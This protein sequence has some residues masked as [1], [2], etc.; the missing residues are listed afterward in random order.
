MSKERSAIK[1]VVAREEIS[2]KDM[3][4]SFFDILEKEGDKLNKLHQ[5]KNVKRVSMFWKTTVT[6]SFDCVYSFNNFFF[7][8]SAYV[9]YAFTYTHAYIYMYIYILSNIN[10]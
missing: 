7:S 2:S 1:S 4:E 3:R 9:Y 6:F 5:G 10:L 8:I